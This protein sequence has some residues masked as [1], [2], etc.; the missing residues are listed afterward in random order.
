VPSSESANAAIRTIDLGSSLPTKIA[1]FRDKFLEGYADAGSNI[2]TG[3]RFNSV[4]D[5]V[6]YL[7]RA[8]AIGLFAPFPQMWFDEGKETGTGG[9]LIAGVETFVMYLFEF[10]AAFAFW[11]MRRR[12][13][14][15][16]LLLVVLIG[17][18]S[19]ALVV[20]NIGALYRMRY[21]YWMLL[22][23][24]GAEGAIRARALW[25]ERKRAAHQL[26]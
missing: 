9:R 10:L 17:V 12:W 24:L 16:F 25:V 6:R 4:G 13:E 20:T 3:M 1:R 2:D 18:V 21:V 22:I 23:P 19:L 11:K 8:L 14:A 5:I 26:A 7:P 15:W